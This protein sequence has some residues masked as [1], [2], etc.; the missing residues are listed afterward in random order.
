MDPTA[1][2][3]YANLIHFLFP[4]AIADRACRRLPVWYWGGGVL[5]R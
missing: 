1:P 4:E 2:Y 3:Y 5:D